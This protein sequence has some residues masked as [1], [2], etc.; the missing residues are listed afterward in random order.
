M[1]CMILWLYPNP[2]IHCKKKKRNGLRN[3]KLSLVLF[4]NL[5]SQNRNQVSINEENL[6]QEIFK[7]EPNQQFQLVDNQ[8]PNQA[9]NPFKPK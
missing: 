9:P 2:L 5:I 7:F 1:L 8:A 4:L 6:S 3:I